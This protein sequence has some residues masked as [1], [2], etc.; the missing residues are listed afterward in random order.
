MNTQADQNSSGPA[1]DASAVGPAN[2]RL[3]FISHATPQDNGFATWV[4]VQ[5]ANAGYEVWCDVAKLLGGEVFWNDITEAIE[6]HAFMVLFCSTLHSNQ[7]PG[8]L[9]ELKIAL[10]V[11]AKRGVTNFLIP[12]KVDQFPFESTQASIRDRNFVR[13]DENWAIGLGQLLKL[14]EREGAPR[15]TRVGPQTV[16]DW[17]RASQDKSRKVV[18]SNERC[19]S[20]WFRL[21]FPTSVFLH[22]FANETLAQR[23]TEALRPHPHRVVGDRIVTFLSADFAA[24]LLPSQIQVRGS[25][26][27]TTSNFIDAGCEA[28]GIAAFD[29]RNMLTDIA[30]Q[31]W[32]EEL[33]RRG[34]QEFELASGMSCYFFKKG[35]LP[36]DRATLA[37]PGRRKT[38][39]QLV[40]TK[41][42]RKADGTKVADGFWHYAVSA[43]AQL[44]PKPRLVIRHHVIFTDD[45]SKPWSNAGRMHRARRRVCKNWWNPEW[46]DRLLAFFAWLSNQQREIPLGEG[47]GRTIRLASVPTAFT[48]PWSYFEDGKDGVD[49]SQEVELVEDDD[50]DDD[51]D[52]AQAA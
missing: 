44:F 35:A 12:L 38:F 6:Q 48:S 19:I 32:G 51:D 25:I 21:R 4:A 15:S 47:D 29:A 3:L 17:Y 39:R 40:G 49:E 2:R 28:A 37:L 16:L 52:D 23:A 50:A 10:D 22:Q 24:T 13:F 43:S 42:R 31:A 1:I 46:R 41:S 8:T 27:V 45:G 9:R 18:I 7:K 14:L 34:L 11:E 36:K 20:N 26:D 33:K 5:L 30:H